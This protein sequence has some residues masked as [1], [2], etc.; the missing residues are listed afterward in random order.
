MLIV[1]AFAFFITAALTVYI[2]FFTTFVES[3]FL[4]LSKRKVSKVVTDLAADVKKTAKDQERHLQKRKIELDSE[5]ITLQNLSFSEENPE[6]KKVR[7]PRKK[8]ESV[9]TSAE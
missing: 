4:C 9:P 6:P 3:I 7:V 5:L 2:I 8:K 1:Q